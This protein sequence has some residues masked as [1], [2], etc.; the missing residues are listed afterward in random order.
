MSHFCHYRVGAGR[1]PA[2]SPQPVV[3]IV[4][5]VDHDPGSCLRERRPVTANPHFCQGRRG[6][7][8]VSRSGPS[9]K[10]ARK[11][12]HFLAIF[13]DVGH[14]LAI[15]STKTRNATPA[16]ACGTG[17]NPASI[18]VANPT[19]ALQRPQAG[20]GLRLG[21]SCRCPVMGFGRSPAASVRCDVE[22]EVVAETLSN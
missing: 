16:F 17:C 20:V 7:A 19:P 5:V 1:R 4:D 11:Y 15:L 3:Q 21:T 6:E 9:P 14:R 22:Q 10:L 8:H 2:R 12:V 13:Q 18:V